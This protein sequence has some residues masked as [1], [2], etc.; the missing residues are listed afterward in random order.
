M[1][2]EQSLTCSKKNEPVAPTALKV[3]KA[4]SYRGGFNICIKSFL[5]CLGISTRC[6]A[7]KV[8]HVSSLVM[9]KATHCP[10]V[11]E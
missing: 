8:L 9:R 4:G 11:D 10:F 1:E 6:H 5:A 7:A 3:L 2:P